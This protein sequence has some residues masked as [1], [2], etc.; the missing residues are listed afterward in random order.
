[1][2][3]I[4]PRVR[5]RAT[6]RGCACFRIFL[7]RLSIDSIINNGRNST[8]RHHLR[9]VICGPD[10]Q[11]FRKGGGVS[12][13]VLLQ[14]QRILVSDAQSPACRGT[15]PE[16]PRGL[17]PIDRSRGRV[18]LRRRVGHRSAEAPAWATQLP[19]HARIQ[20]NDLHLT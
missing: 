9:G 6:K 3:L 19:G 18:R 13:P 17:Q 15:P 11:P 12:G 8:Y 7:V 10:Q 14:G 2:A 20:S 16:Y 1:V 5:S 4:N